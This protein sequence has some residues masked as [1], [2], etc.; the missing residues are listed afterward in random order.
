LT[1]NLID[2]RLTRLDPPAGLGKGAAAIFR[3][4]VASAD[5]THFRRSDL[6][7]LVEYANA[8][9]AAAAAAAE[10]EAGGAVING[11]PSPWLIVQEKSVRAMTALS[12]RLRLSPQSRM[13]RKI[14]ALTNA[15]PASR[16]VEA[17]FEGMH[18][19][20]DR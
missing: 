7:L 20:E 14:A 18:R 19:G 16:G 6:P 13:D 4:L 9:A 12:L 8:C 17:L 5:P 2:T 10:L 3:A 11:R 15:R 1:K